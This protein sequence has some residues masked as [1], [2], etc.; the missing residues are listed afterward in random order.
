KDRIA[1]GYQHASLT[2][3]LTSAMNRRGLFQIGEPLLTRGRFA[4]QPVSLIMFDL[5]YFK[6]INDKFGHGIGDEVL[7]S[8]CRST[9]AQLRPNDLFC[10]IGGEE[11][12]SLL[13]NTTGQEALWIAERVRSEVEASSHVVGEPAVRTTVSAGVAFANDGTTDLA[14][15]LKAADQAL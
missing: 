2:D 1:V 12:V 4:N 10:R 5:D 3:P 14:E 13:P 15:L 9:T 8:F 11:F 6:A 7:V